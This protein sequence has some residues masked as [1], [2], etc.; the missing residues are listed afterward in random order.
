M[1]DK[2]LHITENSIIIDHNFPQPYDSR[3]PSGTIYE[4]MEVSPP[5]NDYFNSK[6]YY[7][8]KFEFSSR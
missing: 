3:K 4:K 6:E 2:I 8:P 7:L 1:K 5:P